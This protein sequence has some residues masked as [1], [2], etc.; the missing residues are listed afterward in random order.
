MSDAEFNAYMRDVFR[1]IAPG[2][3][4]I[5]G[6]SDNVMPR[7]KIERVERITQMVQ[8]FGQYPIS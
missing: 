3:A 1:T 8:E 6:V 4:M 7:A 5:L 2:D